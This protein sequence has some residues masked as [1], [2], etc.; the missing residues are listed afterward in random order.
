MNSLILRDGDFPIHLHNKFLLI[1]VGSVPM[2]MALERELEEGNVLPI[3]GENR[4]SLQLLNRL[5][6]SASG[7]GTAFSRTVQTPT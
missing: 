2:I 7:A 4:M 1:I 5:L 3:D 6:G